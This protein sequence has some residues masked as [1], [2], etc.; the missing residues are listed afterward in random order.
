MLYTS[1][2][3]DIALPSHFLPRLHFKLRS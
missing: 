3:W 1:G 2:S